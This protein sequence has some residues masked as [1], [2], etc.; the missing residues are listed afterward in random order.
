M[1]GL[2]ATINVTGL[3]VF[4]EILAIVQEIVHDIDVPDRHK[5]Q[6]QQWVE[7]HRTDYALDKPIEIMASHAICPLCGT[8]RRY[9]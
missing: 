5:K 8:G 2:K 3:D 7:N 9:D 6:I 4:Q 1:A